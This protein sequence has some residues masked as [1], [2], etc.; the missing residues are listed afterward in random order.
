MIGSEYTRVFIT[1]ELVN[2]FLGKPSLLRQ[3]PSVNQIMLGQSIKLVCA[4]PLS[5]NPHPSVTWIFQNGSQSVLRN[6]SEDKNLI[7]ER[8]VSLYVSGK[9]SNG[10][11]LCNVSNSLGYVLSSPIVV[12]VA[13][14]L[15]CIWGIR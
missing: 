9:E 5:V 6:S 2:V 1:I 4:T 12:I 3:S 11:Y 14:K 13:C 15:K 7:S 10:T 8:E